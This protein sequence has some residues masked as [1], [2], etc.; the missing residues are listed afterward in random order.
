MSADAVEA[1][2]KALAESLKQG[3]E[4]SSGGA[5]TESCGSGSASTEPRGSGGAPTEPRTKDKDKD[6][7]K[8]KPTHRGNKG[9]MAKRAE[10]WRKRHSR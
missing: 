3:G 5:P 6:K 2:F 7:R 4:Q 9:G 10:W 8:G 1:F